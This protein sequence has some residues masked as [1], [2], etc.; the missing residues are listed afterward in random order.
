V[1]IIDP[2]LAQCRYQPDAPAL[3]VPGE[4]HNVISYS[5][6]ERMI[7]NVARYAGRIGLRPGSV[8]VIFSDDPILHACL[9]LGFAKAG[10]IS[11][12][13]R[14]PQLPEELKIDAI[15]ADAGRTFS[16]HTRV[17]PADFA[18]TA[19]DGAPVETAS[20]GADAGALVCRYIFTS[21]TTGD[22]KA[23]AY[24]HRMVTERIAR[25]DYLAGNLFGAAL[26]TYIDLGFATSLGYLFLIRTLT[27]GGMALFSANSSE[28]AMN[29]CDL[30]G[31]RSWVGAP[32]GL[33]PLAQFYEEAPGRRCNF[34]AMLAGGSLV[35]KSLSE[36]VR[37]RMCSNLI[38][39]YGSTETNM[40]ATAPAYVTAQTPGAVGYLTPGMAVQAVDANEQP[41]PAGKEGIIRIRGSYNV[42]GYVDDPE[43]TTR[44][45][46]KGWFYPGDFGI[47]TSSSLL[48]ISGRAKAIMNIGGDK[49]KPEL[50]E[51]VLTSFDAVDEA[52]AFGFLNDYGIEEVWALIVSRAGLDEVQLHAHCQRRLPF[53]FVPRRFIRADALP[54]N[55]MG[56][57][58]RRRLPEM[59]NAGSR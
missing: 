34:E 57:I 3:C 48:I 53:N 13:G 43:E 16:R 29:A 18:W 56:K 22:A 51:D 12:S 17:I 9:I 8:V 58:D 46:R 38:V 1:N 35:S 49:V 41:M 25:F 50:I 4:Y 19:G 5:R 37:M 26:R 10:L 54:K 42:T 2:V 31:V 40:V 20:D 27:R 23:V 7:H 30:Y 55:D 21:G 32:G 44:A 28:S 11:V 36:R 52:G 59:A 47:V 24:T 33:V 14:N 45:F 6:L 15:V 39:A